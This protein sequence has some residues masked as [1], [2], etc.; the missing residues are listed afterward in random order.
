VLLTDSLDPV[1]T[2]SNVSLTNKMLFIK[3]YDLNI[4]YH[5][6]FSSPKGSSWII[7]PRSPPYEHNLGRIFKDEPLTMTHR[8]K[9]CLTRFLWCSYA[10]TTFTE[11]LQGVGLVVFRL[12]SSRVAWI[13]S[14]VN[15]LNIRLIFL[16]TAFDFPLPSLY[17]TSDSNFST[18]GATFQFVRRQ[19]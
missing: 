2:P 3:D 8:P 10:K 17:G 1:I 12:P 7:R 14:L 11:S 15:N 19:T 4:K 13:L 16:K 5:G 9:C 6:H 18:T